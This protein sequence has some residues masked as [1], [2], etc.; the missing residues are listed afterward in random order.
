MILDFRLLLLLLSRFSSVRLC[1][2]IDGSP[3]GYSVPGIL[4]AKILEWVAISFSNAWKWKVKVK[5]LGRVRLLATPWT[6]AYQAPLPMGFSRQEY[7]SGLPLPS[8]LHL[9]IL[10]TIV[11]KTLWN[12]HKNRHI[13]QRKRTEI[14]EI[15]PHLYGQLIYDKGSMN[16]SWGK[17]SLYNK[18]FWE[19]W[20]VTCKRVRLD[21]FLT[22]Y[23][24]KPKMD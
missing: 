23:K 16:I 22:T 5:S 15:N 11:I 12:W 24:S 3:L 17:D 18:R 13:Y 19:N 6:A 4:Q 7:W 8:L 10:Q 9:T 21:D 2:P 20:T 1:D 14:A